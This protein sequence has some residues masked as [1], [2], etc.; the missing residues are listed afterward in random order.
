MT[1]KI[2]CRQH[3][4]VIVVFLLDQKRCVGVWEIAHT[5]IIKKNKNDIC[6]LFSYVGGTD[7]TPPGRGIHEIKLRADQQ[8]DIQQ[9]TLLMPLQ[10]L[11]PKTK[12]LKTLTSHVQRIK[13]NIFILLLYS[14]QGTWSV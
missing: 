5:I 4:F 11:D 7:Y 13:L 8:F 9:G 3:I 2:L 14:F 6:L 10:N 12:Q 1:N